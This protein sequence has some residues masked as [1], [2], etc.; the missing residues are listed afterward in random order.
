MIPKGGTF[1]D[2]LALSLVIVGIG[3]FTAPGSSGP[4]L[5]TSASSGW[6][7]IIKQVTQAGK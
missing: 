6:G 5:L 1:V 2:L 7:T 4:A 3:F